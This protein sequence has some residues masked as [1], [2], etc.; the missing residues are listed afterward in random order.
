[1]DRITV[2]PLKPD[3]RPFFQAQ[4]LE[5]G[6]KKRRTKSLK[7]TDEA[8]AKKMCADL[9]YELN[10]NLFSKKSRM[11]FAAFLQVYM[12]EKL[13]DL[14]RATQ[15]KSRSVLGN[16][17]R[18]SK[19][20]TL[21]DIDDR[22]ISSYTASLRKMG[23]KPHTI[24]GHLSHLRAA[25]YWAKRQKMISVVPTFE[26]PRLPKKTHKR[27][28]TT[29]EYNCLLDFAPT[30]SWRLFIQTAWWTGMRLAEILALRWQAQGDAPYLDL[31]KKRIILPAGCNKAN[32]DQWL[33]IHPELMTLL[34]ARK[35]ET[36]QGMVFAMAQLSN[37]VSRGFYHIARRAGVQ[38]VF[39]DI[40]RTFGTAYA[41]KVPAQVLQR[42]MRHA[43]I[44]T[45]LAYY[46]DQDRGLDEAILLR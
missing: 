41:Q 18:L 29:Q 9:E 45:T 44:K 25:I 4:W 6:S 30:P 2:Y 15:D 7:T 40:R 17:A 23:L 39:H 46:I 36:N 32:E 24:H 16:F 34:L 21:G 1:M 11:P 5:P 12:E 31:P 10:N 13:A 28:I 27:T 22:M 43:N 38:C 35:T 20:A 3:D 42:L 8:T 19:P 37:S 26:M 33:P 14:R